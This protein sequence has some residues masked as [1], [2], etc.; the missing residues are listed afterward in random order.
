MRTQNQH[1]MPASVGANLPFAY[2]PIASVSKAVGFSTSRIY[3][4]IKKGEFPPGDLIGAQS[5]RWKSTDIAN[6]LL[7]Q[8]ELAAQ[9]EA[10]L[11][12]PLKR[13]SAAAVRKAAEMRAS[14]KVADHAAA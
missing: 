12:P 2:L 14:A 1:E 7:R 11:A 10:E 3:E 5:R 4:L 9:R 13:K 6:W 8:S